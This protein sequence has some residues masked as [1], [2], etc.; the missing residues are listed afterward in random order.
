MNALTDEQVRTKQILER[1]FPTAKTSG[2]AQKS[3]DNYNDWLNAITV[4]IENYL[5]QQQQ[6]QQQTNANNCNSI[7]KSNGTADTSGN[8]N[9]D[10]ANQITEELIL[11][12]AKLKTTV[13]EYK[14][15]VAETV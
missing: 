2:A 13:D 14:T 12:N 6:Q 7:S 3:T 8:G 5:Q 9:D 1:L 11:Q 10:G 4:H 15:I